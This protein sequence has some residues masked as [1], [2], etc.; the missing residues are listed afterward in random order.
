VARTYDQFCPLASAL[1]VIGERWTLLAVREL[2]LGPKRF[3]DLLKGLPGISPTLLATRLRD[4]QSAGLVRR[5]ELPPPGAANVYE[6]TEAGKELAPAMVELARWGS[7]RM[8][9]FKSGT[10]FRLGWHLSALQAMHSPEAFRG[11]SETYELRISDEIYDVRMDDGVLD[12]K[13][14]R[15]ADPDLVV[16]MDY[17]TLFALGSGQMT[18]ADA[19]RRGRAT[20][21]GDL[22]TA[23]RCAE[24]LRPRFH[25]PVATE[26]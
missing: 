17:E 16:R 22:A 21:E 13:Q 11:V 23:E 15:S 20:I 24:I 2:R 7:K 25:D 18:V 12:V 5:T 14:G 19:L 1:D 26:S 4:M 9:R 10:H 3:T 6:L 8:D